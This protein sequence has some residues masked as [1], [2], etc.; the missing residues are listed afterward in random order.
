MVLRVVLQFVLALLDVGRVASVGHSA[1]VSGEHW[2]SLVH[3]LL[4]EF[5]DLAARVLVILD[6]VVHHEH[7]LLGL[8]PLELTFFLLL[9]QVPGCGELFILGLFHA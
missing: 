1:L 3:H 2:L 4:D 6:A 5:L 7:A 8:H 9:F